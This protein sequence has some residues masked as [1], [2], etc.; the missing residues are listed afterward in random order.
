[1]ARRGSVGTAGS[2]NEAAST[3]Q[4]ISANT[5]QSREPGR[6]NGRENSSPGRISFTSD[7]IAARAY[8][9]YEREGRTDGRDMDH[10][11]RAERELREERERE[12]PAAPG[13]AITAASSAST[14]QNRGAAPR[15][16]R[17]DEAPRSARRHQSSMV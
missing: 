15:P 6:G 17:P 11:L 2:Q 13:A 10:W 1:M 3:G 4:V 5:A 12:N 9:I 8:E 16:P 14:E 7:E